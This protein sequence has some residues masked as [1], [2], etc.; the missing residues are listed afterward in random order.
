MQVQ[1]LDHLNLTVR[2]LEETV[3]WY[4]RVFGFELVEDGQYEGRPWGI[5]RSG[6]ALLCIYERPSDELEPPK[7][8][9]AA[10]RQGINHFALT[11]TDREAWEATIER[12]DVEVSYGGEITW[13][14][15]DS[16]YVHDPTGYEIEV[17]LWH[18]GTPVFA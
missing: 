14:H 17:A 16:W 3:D 7:Q 18:E 13:P 12:E 10:G 8:R 15:S 11:I 1:R 5:I 4:G 2:S 6:D 9:K